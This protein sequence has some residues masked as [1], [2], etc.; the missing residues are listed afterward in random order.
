[1][2]KARKDNL[3]S[4]KVS[5]RQRLPRETVV[6]NVGPDPGTITTEPKRGLVAEDVEA[7][8]KA[9]INSA[10]AKERQPSQLFWTLFATRINKVKHRKE[11]ERLIRKLSG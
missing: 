1:M 3:P 11:L 9:T 6:M 7:I 8:R 4:E 5:S 10:L 2:T